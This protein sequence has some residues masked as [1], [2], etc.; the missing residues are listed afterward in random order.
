MKKWTLFFCLVGCLLSNQLLCYGQTGDTL[1]DEKFSSQSSINLTKTTAVVDTSKQEVRLPEVNGAQSVSTN[2]NG[3][4]TI[5]NGEVDFF[6]DDGNGHL[7]KNTELSHSISSNPIA[8]AL[9]DGGYDHYILSSDGKV[10]KYLYAGGSWTQDPAYQLSGFTSAISIAQSQNSL[11]VL[12]NHQVRVFKPTNS[13]VIEIPALDIMLN[14][15]ENP[16]QISTMGEDLVVRDD[17]ENIHYYRLGTMYNEDPSMAVMGAGTVMDAH[18]GNLLTMKSGNFQEYQSTGSN[19]IQNAYVSFTDSNAFSLA[20]NTDGSVMVRDN[21][22]LKKYVLN[23]NA[24]EL[25]AQY[26]GLASFSTIYLQPRDMET[27][28]YTWAT[29][30]SRIQV[31]P[32]EVLPPGTSIDL[33]VSGDHGSTFLPVDATGYVSFSSP[34]TSLIIHAVLKTSD[35]TQTPLLKELQVI[36]TTL[37]ITDF[38]TTRIVRDPGGN[39]PLPTPLPCRVVG[40]YNFDMLVNAPGATQVTVNFSNGETVILSQSGSTFTGSHFFPQDAT[41]SFDVTVIAKDGTGNQVQRVLPAQ[42][43]ITTNIMSK[44]VIYDIK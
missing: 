28:E 2:L 20:G 26:N 16:L 35:T 8:A 36:D 4:I 5:N 11:F 10:S 32:T 22:T 21:T 14:N 19:F 41:G 43:M 17:K 42:Y 24:M 12:D 15:I 33:S 25:S 7:V 34:I 38:E 6:Q 23:G 40:G 13:G 31:N 1:V 44:A 39:P 27:K 37:S 3:T 30:T 29:P 18:S 9:T